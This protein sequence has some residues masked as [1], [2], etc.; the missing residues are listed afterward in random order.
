MSVAINS[1]FEKAFASQPDSIIKAP[2]RVNLIGEHTDYNDGFVLPCAIDFATWVAIKPNG[3]RQVRLLAMDYDHQLD[4]FDLDQELLPHPNLQ[5]SN[6]VRGVF[7]ELIK[8]GHVVDGCD[9]A[10]TGNV[11]QG[12]GLSSSASLEVAIA[13]ALVHTFSLSLSVA[14]IAIIAQAAEN[15]FVGCNCGIMDQL[16]S[17]CGSSNSALLIDCRSLS[18]TPAPLL[19]GHSVVIIN[20]NVKRGLVDSKYN[21]R[22]EQCQQAAAHFGL[23][24]L[25]DLPLSQFNAHAQQ[26]DPLIAKR[27]RHVLEENQRT[28]DAVEALSCHDV[29]RLSELMAQSHA[30]MRDLFEITTPEIDYLVA[31]IA[32]FIKDK[33]GARMTGGGFGGCVVAVVADELVAPMIAL[34]DE[35]YESKTGLKESVYITQAAG[36]VK[37]L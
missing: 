12:S 25:R 31:L 6:Y 11:P 3:T 29:A 33:G 17:A 4:S 23:S 18:L 22:R 16:I 7:S 24:S 1:A 8:A 14:E 27:A 28:L 36:G 37:V 15:N 20:S 30:S 13:K 10:I 34:V 32:D 26:L 2:G 35:C 19:K 21:E 9:I 5:W